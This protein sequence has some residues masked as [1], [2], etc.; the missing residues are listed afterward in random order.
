MMTA[1]TA[2]IGLGTAALLIGRRSSKLAILP[3]GFC[4]GAALMSP[5]ATKTSISPPV[6]ELNASNGLL[7]DISAVK[8]RA[9]I[10]MDLSGFPVNAQYLWCGVTGAIVLSRGTLKISFLT[11]GSLLTL[12]LPLLRQES[13]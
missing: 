6:W 9:C 12:L 2:S 5:V 4:T 7:G 1:L 3:I 11:L 8:H 10:M 13:P